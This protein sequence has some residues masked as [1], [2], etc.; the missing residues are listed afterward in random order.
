MTLRYGKTFVAEEDYPAAETQAGKYLG[1]ID[2]DV[3]TFKGIEYAYADRFHMPQDPPSFGGLREA[4]EYGYGVPEMTYDLRG[5]KPGDGVEQIGMYWN[6][7]EHLH[8]LN[9]WT[10][11]LDPEAKKPVIFF[12]HGGGYAGGAANHLFIYDGWALAAAY[13]VVMVSIN[14]RLNMLGYLDLSSF[15]ERYRYSGNLGQADIVAA[16]KWVKH[17][18]AAFGGDPDNVTLVGQSGGGGK[19]C[20]LLQMPAA[21]GLYHKAV[22]QS[23][24]FNTG[25][26]SQDSPKLLGEETAKVLGLT[27]ETIR[28]I[29]TI[30]YDTL[31]AAV[32]KAGENLGRNMAFGGWGPKADGEYYLGD[33]RVVGFREETTMML[34]HRANGGVSCISSYSGA[35]SMITRLLAGY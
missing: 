11:S 1:Y 5:K 19:I 8:Y 30:D 25:M 35:V 32:L 26:L 18:I 14:H 21:D 10:R 4:Y 13:D 24:V 15:G 28:Q 9:V 29:E 17:N 20:T 6:M 16:L 12:I 31:A 33:P 27:K 2:D 23:G 7:D 22:I 34:S 3:F